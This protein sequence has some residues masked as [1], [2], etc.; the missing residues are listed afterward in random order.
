MINDM[1]KFSMPETKIISNMLDMSL[2]VEIKLRFTICSLVIFY[3]PQH[4]D[5]LLYQ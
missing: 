4:V 2:E 3:L 5:Q 1:G